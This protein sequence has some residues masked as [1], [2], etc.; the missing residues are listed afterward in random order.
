LTETNAPGRPGRF[1]AIRELRPWAVLIGSLV[2]NLG[3]TLW[4]LAYF[5]MRGVPVASDTPPAELQQGIDTIMQSTG[6]AAALLAIGMG[7]VVIGAYA[8]GRLGKNAPMLNGMAVSVV[9]LIVTIINEFMATGTEPLWYSVIGYAL[10]L[11]AGW[12]GA[13]MAR[14]HVRRIASK[15]P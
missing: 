13:A 5:A 7:F 1:A 10:V 15:E 12:A 11:P 3:T 9:S 14:A 4:G 6:D 2:D 8:G